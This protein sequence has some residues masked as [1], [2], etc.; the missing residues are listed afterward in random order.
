MI[1]SAANPKLAQSLQ[2]AISLNGICQPIWRYEMKK[3]QQGFTLIELM[4][5]IAI[6]GILAAVAL[7][8]YENYTKRAKFAEVVSSVV[9]IRNAIDVCV[10][11]TGV[12]ISAC[13]LATGSSTLDEEAATANNVDNVTWD[14]AAGTITA[15]GTSDVDDKTYILAGTKD[16]SYNSVTWSVSTSSTCLAA[17]LC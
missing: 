7:P 8:A 3:V 5:V 10:Q 17:G 9:P 12:A 11:T 13:P 15:T 6:V 1:L 2:H 16:G 14:L 4:I